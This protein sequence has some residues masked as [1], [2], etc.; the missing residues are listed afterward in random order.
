M[1]DPAVA[2][3]G[4]PVMAIQ[5]LPC[6]GGFWVCCANDCCMQLSNRKQE[7]RDILMFGSFSLIVA[8]KAG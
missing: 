6:S 3:N 4:L 2:A 5:F 1:M 7:I 8:G